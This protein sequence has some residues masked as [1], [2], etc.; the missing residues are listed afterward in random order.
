MRQDEKPMLHLS[1]GVI[2]IA[3]MLWLAIIGVW[4][5][6]NGEM[7]PGIAVILLAGF[8]MWRLLR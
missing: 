7:R 1:V 6:I 2:A 3:V 8:C 4:L 5:L